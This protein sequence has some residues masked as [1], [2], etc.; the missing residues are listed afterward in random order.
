VITILESIIN[1]RIQAKFW[2]S[3]KYETKEC[4]FTT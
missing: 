4:A 1:H 2:P 3:L